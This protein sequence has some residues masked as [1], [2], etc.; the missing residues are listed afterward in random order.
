MSENILLHELYK[1][2]RMP[3]CLKNFR[4]FLRYF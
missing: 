1:I 2:K 4:F 3:A